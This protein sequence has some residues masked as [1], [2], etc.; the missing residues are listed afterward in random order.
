MQ[1][2]PGRP[3]YE[4]TNGICMFFYFFNSRIA[5]ADK[6]AEFN[7]IPGRVTGNAHFTKKD[8]IATPRFCF[9]DS[10]Y[11]LPGIAPEIA[12][13]IILLGQKY[14]HRVK[15]RNSFDLTRYC[16]NKCFYH[17]LLWLNC[18][19]S[20]KLFFPLLVVLAVAGCKSQKKIP[21]VSGINISLAVDRF[22]KD[23][24]N[25]DTIHVDQALN[26]LN[27][28][29]PGFTQ[30]FLFNILGTAPDSAK[31][32]VPTFVNSYKGLYADADKKF[33]DI[34]GITSQ[35]KQAFRFVHY[36]FPA[37]KLP[38]RMVTFIGPIN[39]YGSILTPDALAV[40]LQLYMGNDY[41]LYKSQ[42]GQEMYPLFISRRF[43]PAYI[44]V[45]G[46]KN[47]IDDMYPANAAG[48]PLVEQM[49][50]SGKRLYLLDLLLP[51]LPDTLKTGYTA[52]QLEG[53]YA[54]E[55]NIWTFFV[56]NDMLYN[57]DP[58]VT[59]DYMNDAPNTTALGEE[60]PGNIGQ[61]V[62]FQIVKKWMEKN[63]EVSPA[64]LMKTPA[65]QIFEEAKYK[66][67]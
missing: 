67:R 8:Q 59:R 47:I 7:K 6:I 15:F 31:H 55:K 19:M 57:T 3:A 17:L 10:R 2:I 1:G 26:S 38:S 61:F 21:D 33:G 35:V 63:K 30:D 41:P 29:H 62:G 5:L 53:C 66:P 42:Q 51:S 54:S 13:M 48:K 60:S 9:I 49:V 22:E 37:Y 40:G 14:F 45:N 11:Y 28:K 27:K 58:N 46:V 34:T 39:S 65:K 18:N 16:S 32:Q 43:E 64:V 20:R 52:K 36:Y 44:P 4:Y 12:D 56:Q 25:M 50:E 24:F 23:L